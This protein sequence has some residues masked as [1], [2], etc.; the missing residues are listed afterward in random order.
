MYVSVSLSSSR[1]PRSKAKSSFSSF[2]T[3]VACVCNQLRS[4][5]RRVRPSSVH[6]FRLHIWFAYHAEY[7]ECALLSRHGF[8]TAV[9]V[10]PRSTEVCK[11]ERKKFNLGIAH[12]KLLNSWI[13]SV[14]ALSD[15]EKL[16]DFTLR[17]NIAAKL[18]LQNYGLKK[19]N[20]SNERHDRF[21]LQLEDVFVRYTKG[22]T[23][24]ITCSTDAPRHTVLARTLVAS[25]EICHAQ[26]S[27]FSCNCL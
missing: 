21:Y 19:V 9:N 1:D 18:T 12:G 23:H 20:K 17:K 2:D 6:A 13:R 26:V 27:A 4:R 15:R 16:N 25:L 7:K 11:I 22:D 24:C 3:V 5:V 14:S 8:K 10:T